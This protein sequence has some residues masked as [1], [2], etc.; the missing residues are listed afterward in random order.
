MSG[1][2]AAEEGVGIDA[3]LAIAA[4]E[5]QVVAGRAAGGRRSARRPRRRCGPS[6]T[7]ARP[8][9]G[10]EHGVGDGLRRAAREHHLAAAGARAARPPARGPASTATRADLALVVDAGRIAAGALQPRDHGLHRLRPGGRGGRV[11]EVVAGHRRGSQPRSERGDA[12][13]VAVGQRGGDG[14]LG[15]AVERGRASPSPCPRSTAQMTGCSI[16]TS[17]NGQWLLMMRSSL[18]RLSVWAAKPCAVSASATA[19]RAGPER[20]VDARLRRARRCGR[21][22]QRPGPGRTPGPTSSAMASASSRGSRA[23]ARPRRVS[24]RSSVLHRGVERD[25][26]ADGPVALG[27]PARAGARACPRRPRGS[28]RRPACPGGGGRRWGGARTAPPPGRP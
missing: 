24:T 27:R 19:C 16:A 2:T 11:V 21:S 9:R 1:R 5:A 20:P 10:A 17:P 28:R 22:C 13:V 15:L 12:H 6:G 18:L 3:A 25:P 26:L 23:S 4:D 7:R 8:A 14:R